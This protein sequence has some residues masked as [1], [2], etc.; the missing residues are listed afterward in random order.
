M[1][2]IYNTYVPDCGPKG[3]PL[4]F[5]GESPGEDEEY[6]KEPFVGTAG[7]ILMS[8][9]S[10]HGIDKSNARFSNLCHYR[11]FANK[12]EILLNT[13]QLKDGLLE[14]HEY[15]HDHN[16]VVIGALGKW[17][18]AMLTGRSGIT[19]FRGSILPCALEGCEH[20]KVIPTFHPAYIARFV[21]DSPIF[22]FD[23][24]RIV[25][26][27]KFPEFNYPE[28]EFEIDPPHSL[29]S[30]VVDELLNARLLAVDIESVK[31]TNTIICVG[32]ADST[33]HSVVFP[34]NG[35]N[36]DTIRMLL[37]SDIP[38]I[39]QFGTYDTEILFNNGITVNNY[40][41]DTLTLEHIL[42]PELPRS[43]EFLCSIYTRQPYY[44]SE[45]RA[46]LPDDVKEWAE[47]HDRESIYIYNARDC[48]VTY[49]VWLGQI[50]DLAE[51]DS[52]LGKLYR[53]E[54][55]QINESAQDITRYGGLLI[56]SERRDILQKTLLSNWVKYQYLLNCATG[57]H[58]NVNSTKA[59]P[60]LLYETLK[61]P[62]RRKQDKN[63]ISKPT[64]DEDAIVNLIGYVKGYIGGLKTDKSIGEWE[65]KLGILKLILRIRG[66]RKLLSTYVKV[67]HSYDF[68]VRSAVK[69]AATETGR[70]S[71]Q[72]YFDNTGLN[73]QT[74]PRAIIEIP[75]GGM[76][77]IEAKIDVNRLIN[78]LVEEVEEAA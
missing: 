55:D 73:A 18:T 50:Q 24:D 14:L 12:F 40:D 9:L 11:P 48:C 8:E 59:V 64:A 61:L 34:W 57:F 26:D 74:I 72:K 25:S 7:Q 19:K 31:N 36:I 68:R 28:Y 4:L 49:A 10:K 23:I 44:K 78:E 32:F 71:M 56:D 67:K 62:V 27:S 29:N 6:A 66:I 46:E 65:I 33:K 70:W 1:S 21:N 13:P 43:L 45:G 20:I 37:E 51:R 42:E 52:Q 16:P 41:H 22:A 30:G 53:F 75:T 38:K 5:V 76:Q 58:L 54:M 15:I 69:V 17:P 3:S 63:G 2:K 35:R 60:K 77:D 39:F 47:K